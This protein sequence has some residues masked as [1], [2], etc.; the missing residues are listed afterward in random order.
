M[1]RYRARRVKAGGHV[2]SAKEKR[3][4]L[5]HEGSDT[6]AVQFQRFDGSLVFEESDSVRLAADSV[7]GAEYTPK[8]QVAPRSGCEP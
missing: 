3:P 1:Q 5:R 8:R 4:V 7:F 6:G 2:Q